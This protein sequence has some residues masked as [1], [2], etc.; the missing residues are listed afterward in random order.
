MAKNYFKLSLGIFCLLSFSGL[1]AQTYTHGRITATA[2][3]MMS[4]DSTSCSSSCGLNFF[5]TVD[6][7]YLGDSL[8]IVDMGSASLLSAYG[9]STGAT[10]WSFM[11][12]VPIYNSL[13]I[14]NQLLS[15]TASFVGPTIKMVSDTDTIYSI[16]NHYS[17]LVTNPCSYGSVSGTVYVDNNSNC[18][19]D[20]G[21]VALNALEVT[22]TAALSSPGF[23]SI[24][25]YAYSGSTGTYS[26]SVQQSW[27]TSYTVS[28]PPDYV[29][30]FPITP[31]FTGAYTYTTLP[32]SAA[33]FP[34]QC[35]G[36]TDVQCWAGS[37]AAIRVA[38]PF[39]MQPYVSNLGCDTASGQL[40]FVKDS[41]VTYDPSL[42]YNPA[43]VVTGDTLI[44]YYSNL[45][46]LSSGAYWNSFLSS[47]HLTPD[48]SVHV[49][50]TLCFRLYAN[51]PAGDINPANNDFAFCLPVVYSYDPNLKEVSPKGTGTPGYIP[52]TTDTLTYTIH[53][54]NT[55]T[56]Y[57]TNV[58]IIDTLDSHINP[59]SLKILGTSNTLSPVWLAPGIVQFNFNNINLPDSTD[60]E[61]GSHGFVRFYVELNPGLTAGTQIKNTGYIYFD[62]NPAVVTNTA[63]NTIA[64]DTTTST[65]GTAIVAAGNAVKIYP[66]P[67]TDH[68]FVENLQNGTLLIQDINGSTII[69]QLITDNKTMVDISTLSA[70]MYMLKCIN[71]NEVTVSKFTKY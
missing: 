40:T 62:T 33:D 50:D 27:M 59:T 9:N 19:Y 36:N 66:N 39:F 5:I 51:I 70:G 15:S 63:L 8:H 16:P 42:S 22:S 21:D 46:N 45:T 68:I 71:K 55:G 11:A 57:A 14:D 28:L 29:F 53:F 23:P 32:Q 34:L 10:S 47:I 65:T 67:A 13:I 48:T 30:I 49:G 54:Q 4:H 38:T 35:T 31:C 61:A 1:H 6:S 24:S 52:A 43:V 44:W 37:P 12:T 3:P 18:V 64:A 2:N 7:S 60:N 58:S 56:S 41:R 20:A 69:S 17:L 25:S 26:M